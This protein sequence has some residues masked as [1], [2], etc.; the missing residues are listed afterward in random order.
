G[1]SFWEG[2]SIVGGAPWLAQRRVLASAADAAHR[3][4]AVRAAIR[5]TNMETASCSCCVLT[6]ATGRPAI[7][8][9]SAGVTPYVWDEGEDAHAKPDGDG[10][11]CAWRDGCGGTGPCPAGGLFDARDREP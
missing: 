8:A 11:A 10:S 6:L 7:N 3:A 1:P 5:A 2:G 4:A 9:A